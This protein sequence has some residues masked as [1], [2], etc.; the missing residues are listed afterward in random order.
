MADRDLH[1]VTG[2]FGYSGQYIARRLLDAGQRVRTLT[3]S[4]QRENPFGGKVEVRPYNFDDPSA[5][6]NSLRGA[7]VLYN[8]YWVRFDHIDFTHSQAVQNTL[9]LFNAAKEAGIKRVVH[10][11]ITNPS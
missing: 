4:P 5:L 7:A 8:T 3:N 11:S 2:A 10:V 9:T 1:V 6:V